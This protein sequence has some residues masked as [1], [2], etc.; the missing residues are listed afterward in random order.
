[1]ALLVWCWF[2]SLQSFHM[3]QFWFQITYSILLIL[4]CFFSDQLIQF[5]MTEN[6]LPRRF[7]G[8]QSTRT[9]YQLIPS[10]LVSM[11]EPSVLQTVRVSVSVLRL[12]L[13]NKFPVGTA[14]LEYTWVDLDRP[15]TLV[16]IAL[17]RGGTGYELTGNRFYHG[18]NQSFASL[19]LQ[20]LALER[21][22]YLWGVVYCQQVHIM[23][24]W[25]NNKLSSYEYL[26]QQIHVDQWP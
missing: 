6:C 16:R 19:T 13:L 5:L 2:R 22:M 7:L 18:K 20:K 25:L 11:S 9:Q 8:I 10:E 17:V 26:V 14:V 23:S 4:F 3:G 12:L 15:L 1:M 21:K 24:P